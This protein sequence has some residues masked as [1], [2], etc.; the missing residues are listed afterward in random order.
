MMPA[1]GTSR[2]FAAMGNLVASGH[3]GHCQAALFIIDL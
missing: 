1:Y 3:R 2:H